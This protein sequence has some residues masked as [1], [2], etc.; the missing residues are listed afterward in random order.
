M[1]LKKL[2]LDM[3]EQVYNIILSIPDTIVFS[4]PS[5]KSPFV[6]TQ[7]KR[8]RQ[9]LKNK[10]KI[11]NTRLI[12]EYHSVPSNSNNYGFGTHENK[13]RTS[14]TNEFDNS[15]NYG[16]NSSNNS[17]LN[18]T[19]NQ[20]NVCNDVNS[21][22]NKWVSPDFE[23]NN[24]L[25]KRLTSNHTDIYIRERLNVNELECIVNDNHFDS[26]SDVSHQIIHNGSENFIDKQSTRTKLETTKSLSQNNCEEGNDCL[27]N[28]IKLS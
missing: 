14:I 1:D 12:N 6:L 5:I 25:P 19:S 7:L 27:L 21:I 9:K 17:K 8:M 13:L 28:S 18:K 15:T 20:N 24:T 4:I 10:M 2:E 16:T 22:T 23:T 11:G 3:L 26:V